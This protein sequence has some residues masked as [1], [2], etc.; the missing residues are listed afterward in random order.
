MPI[1][2]EATTQVR[3]RAARRE[4]AQPQA[5]GGELAGQQQSARTAQMRSLRA[6]AN[7]GPQLRRLA[8]LAS[9]APV[10]RYSPRPFERV[11]L[12]N[13]PGVPGV[14]G[15]G[16]NGERLAALT[17]W[18]KSHKQLLHIAHNLR[19]DAWLRL[20]DL[21]GAGFNN[22][23]LKSAPDESNADALAAAHIMQSLPV[24][25]L[26]LA[27]LLI[28]EH[29]EEVVPELKAKLPI[30]NA[31]YGIGSSTA[32]AV[33]A[34]QKG[35]QQ[36]L[37]SKLDVNQIVSVQRSIGFEFEFARYHAPGELPAHLILG[38]SAELST[39]FKMPFVL[40][41]DSGNELEIGMPPMLIGLVEDGPDKDT[42]SRL[43]PILRSTMKTIRDQHI[44]SPVN[45][46]PLAGNGIGAGWNMK[47]AANNLTVVAGRPGKASA[48]A[49]Q[50]YSQLNITL[51]PAE[52][53]RFTD[54]EG[55]RLYLSKSHEFFGKAYDAIRTILKSAE[56]TQGKQAA[57][58][59]SK[60]LSNLLAVPSFLFQAEYPD[61]TG[62]ADVSSTVKEVFGIWVKDSIP[63]IVDNALTDP[64]QRKAMRLLLSQKTVEI[65]AAMDK[66]MT[67]ANDFLDGDFPFGTKDTEGKLE[68][69]K[70]TFLVELGQTLLK[71]QQRLSA[72][73]PSYRVNPKLAFG[74]ET[75]PDDEAA[76]RGHGVRKDTFVNVPEGER[77]LHLAEL[78]NDH[79]INSFLGK[80]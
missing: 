34:A 24:C 79:F 28:E 2:D 60:G 46:L 1:H 20:Q 66:L 68:R 63:N 61:V 19:Y 15:F 41:T 44:D 51:T 12:N 58:H 35:L 30:V 18:S 48:S 67:D 77:R 59:I 57:I 49:D 70:N 13:L 53:A 56:G 6:V 75:F 38:E 27:R 39:L 31:A 45:T 14:A 72:D 50:V 42:I 37:L 65:E 25:L 80:R 36:W 71:L 40:E 9:S 73:V 26:P 22:Q 74:E 21:P 5:D 4:A 54:G 29:G 33:I 76:S 62:N 78:R 43:W 32:A 64:E 17:A 47:A 10:Q 3:P 52:I 7:S 55:K 8:G 69:Y 16:W 23:V 11:E